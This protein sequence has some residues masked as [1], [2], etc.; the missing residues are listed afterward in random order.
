MNPA[1]ASNTAPSLT[2]P[3]DI[4][5]EA[6]GGSGAAVSYTA[7]ASDAQDGSLAPTCSPASG[8]TFPLGI[9]QVDCSVT[10][11]GGMTTQGMFNVAVVDT[12]APVLSLPAD[13][14]EE[15]TGPNGAAVS[16]S[17]SARDAVDGSI[18]PRCD[19]QSGDTFPLETATVN[20]SATDAAG[21]ISRGSFTVT[22]RDTTAPALTLPSDIPGSPPSTVRPP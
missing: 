6:T 22:V 21:N 15:A 17:S 8:A 10:D 12:T 13:K 19:A 2:L 3:A 4:T 20:C 5:V 9:T 16:F 11:S 7:S 18:A 14:T 1:P